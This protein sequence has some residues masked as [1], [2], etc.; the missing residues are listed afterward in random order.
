MERSSRRAIS[1]GWRQGHQ[2]TSQD[3]SETR[4]FGRFMGDRQCVQRASEATGSVVESVCGETPESPKVRRSN[5]RFARRLGKRTHS[6]E[7][8]LILRLAAPRPV[9]QRYF[10]E[11]S[12]ETSMT[13]TS[14]NFPVS[15][16]AP[17][18]VS[19]CFSEIGSMR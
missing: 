16:L 12:F 11:P 9:Q 8:R 13:S 14:S 4:H 10:L 19:N 15:M 5:D 1:Q 18:T 2:Y 6:S 3:R 7:R 17:P